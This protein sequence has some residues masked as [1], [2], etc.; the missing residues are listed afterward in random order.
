M[1]YE[2]FGKRCEV[3]GVL[4]IDLTCCLSSA[5]ADCVPYLSGEGILKS[6]IM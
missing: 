2:E 5:M 1:R 6:S 4:I 3:R